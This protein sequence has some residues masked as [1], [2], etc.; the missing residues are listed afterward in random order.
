MRQR[1][2]LVYSKWFSYSKKTKIVIADP[3]YGIGLIYKLV[4]CKLNIVYILRCSV[5]SKYMFQ[6]EIMLTNDIHK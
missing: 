2:E 1:Q 4:I 6:F 3:T 5:M